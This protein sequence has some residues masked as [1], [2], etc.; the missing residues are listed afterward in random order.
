MPTYLFVCSRNL[1]RSPAAAEYFSKILTESGAEGNVES[2]GIHMRARR[3]LTQEMLAGAD[4]VFALDEQIASAI[5]DVWKY[6]E[7]VVDLGISDDYLFMESQDLH[8]ALEEKRGLM[9]AKIRHA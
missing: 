5:K 6:E 8:M 9:E 2:A 7:E 4:V 1:I 3:R